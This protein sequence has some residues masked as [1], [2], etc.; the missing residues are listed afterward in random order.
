ML[1]I[2]SFICLYLAIP[3][4][5]Y[6]TAQVIETFEVPT[7]ETALVSKTILQDGKEYQL[8]SSGTFF[9]GGPG[10]GLADTD[11][12]DFSNPPGSVMDGDAT[13]KDRIGLSIDGSILDWGPFTPTHI[14]TATFVGKKAPIEILY[15]DTVYFDNIGSLTLELID[16]LMIVGD[17]NCDGLINLL[18]VAPFVEILSNGTFDPKADINQ[19]GDV[20]LLDVAPFVALLTG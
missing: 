12:F 15:L 5:A 17:V 20:D 14:Y 6:L 2:K 8:R 10:D 18:D 16:P 9:I 11:Y 13:G 7:D 4:P 19:D 3:F 1:N